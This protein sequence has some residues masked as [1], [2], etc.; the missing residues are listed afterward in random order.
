MALTGYVARIGEIRNGVHNF[1]GK[2]DGR[3]PLVRSCISGEDN[4]KMDRREIV[5]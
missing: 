5:V 2:P 3:S 4:T 1:G